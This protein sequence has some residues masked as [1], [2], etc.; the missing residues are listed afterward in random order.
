MRDGVM[1]DVG[2]WGP[3]WL[4]ADQRALLQPLQLLR[5]PRKAEAKRREE[6]QYATVIQCSIDKRQASQRRA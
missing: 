1:G 2:G 4:G 3:A 5:Q 6:E